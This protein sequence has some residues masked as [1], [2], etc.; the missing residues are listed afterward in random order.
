MNKFGG[1]IMQIPVEISFRGMDRLQALADDIQERAQ[2]L[3]GTFD[4]ITRCEVVVEAPHRRH[5]QGNLYR[6]RIQLCVPR[7]ELIVGHTAHDKHQHEDPFVAVRDAF[8]AMRRQLLDY[9]Q[10][11]RGET[12]M[13][14]D[15]PHGLIAKICLPDGPDFP[16]HGYGVIT[17]CDG[18][19][20]AFR[21][22]SLHDVEFQRLELG[23][24][25][26]FIEEEGDEGPQATS[27]SLV[28]HH[29]VI[30]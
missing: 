9:A 12:K 20:V 28:G 30:D 25:V 23:S 13:H 17:T 8:S 24:E 7:R 3:A 15:S 2:K 16:Q 14:A 4:R 29:Q 22:S 6:V 27:V 19:N 1:G 18:R 10:E 26:D 11:L 5:A 21:A